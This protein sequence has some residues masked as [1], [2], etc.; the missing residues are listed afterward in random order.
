MRVPMSVKSIQG[1]ALALSVWLLVCGCTTIKEA[2]TDQ[3]TVAEQALDLL[4]RGI[5]TDVEILGRAPQQQIANPTPDQ[6]GEMTGS[7]QAIEHLQGVRIDQVA[8][9]AVR[10]TP[11]D[12]GLAWLN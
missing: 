3:K 2:A 10:V 12:D 1:L 11:Q 5:G 8:R 7:M 4:R 6:I 9:E